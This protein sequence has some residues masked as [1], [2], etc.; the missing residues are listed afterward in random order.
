MNLSF[1]L[2]NKISPPNVFER[3]SKNN[4]YYHT[5]SDMASGFCGT[6]LMP[7]FK[8]DECKTFSF[9]CHFFAFTL[10]YSAFLW[11][12][13]SFYLTF[14]ISL[15]ETN[16]LPPL[17]P[18]ILATTTLLSECATDHPKTKQLQLWVRSG[19]GTVVRRIQCLRVTDINVPQIVDF[20]DNVTL[21]CSYDI[22]GHTLNSV[23][24]YKNGKEFFR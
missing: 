24:W 13:S 21:S 14:F 7:Q 4:F 19:C 17:S 18:L 10:F 9:R 16:L 6:G 15:H 22:S 5:I 20:R 12:F 23:K 2:E 1:L 11:H 3:G 8:A